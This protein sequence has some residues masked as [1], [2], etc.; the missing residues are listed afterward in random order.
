MGESK[1][2]LTLQESCRGTTPGF[3]GLLGHMVSKSGSQIPSGQ[4]G[5]ISYRRPWSRLLQPHFCVPIEAEG[6]L[7]TDYRPFSVKPVLTGSSFQDGNHQVGSCSDASRRLGSITGPT[8]HASS[9][10]RASRLPALSSILLQRSSIPVQG[11]AFLTDIS[12]NREGVCGTAAHARAK[13]SR[14]PR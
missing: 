5:D 6:I 1:V 8:G 4:R 9:R 2:T 7:E 13:T 14:V 10:P 3:H 12:V 11:Y